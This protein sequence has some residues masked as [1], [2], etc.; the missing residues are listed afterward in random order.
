[1]MEGGGAGGNDADDFFALVARM[2]LNQPTAAA[3]KDQAPTNPVSPTK[4]TPNTPGVDDLF[5]LL[6]KG[7]NDEYLGQRSEVLS[8]SVNVMQH[9]GGIGGD[10]GGMS[11][12]AR[13]AST[14]STGSS[15]SSI[16]DQ[17]AV[18]L[19]KICSFFSTMSYATPPGISSGGGASEE[20]PLTVTPDGMI[21]HGDSWLVGGAAAAGGVIGGGGG[22]TRA[23]TAEAGMHSEVLLAEADG[24]MRFY[25]DYFYN[26][27]HTNFVG[28]SESL[29]AVVVS[30]RRETGEHSN[31]R[32][33]RAIVR[34][35]KTGVARLTI[36]ESKV[37]ESA[38]GVSLT[39]VLSSV[40][41]T[42]V[43]REKCLFHAKLC[44]ALVLR[45]D[46]CVC[47]R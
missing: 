20:Q 34:S 45:R 2:Q 38:G 5:A 39:D 18:P 3:A 14:I 46:H 22:D 43:L 30:L 23:G 4:D 27:D 41:P 26:Q 6:A 11:T 25:A 29:G 13:P 37:A 17:S 33:Y 16:A 9:A 7:Q 1:M 31:H 21:A 8:P 28:Q 10:F 36:N 44:V 40:L 35:T 19:H 12:P 15:K 24:H 42:E 47:S 32:Q